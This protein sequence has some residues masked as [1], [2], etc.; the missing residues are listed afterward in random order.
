MSDDVRAASLRDL[1][2][3]AA[4]AAADATER[5]RRVFSVG[6]GVALLVALL[7]IGLV[8]RGAAGPGR[9]P[10][11]GQP[12]PD[13]ALT[14]FDGRLMRLSDLRGRPV[15]LNFWAS[16][17]PPCRAEAP[18]LSKVAAQ[19]GRV[20]FL[21]VDVRDRAGDAQ[22]FVNEFH[23]PYPN[24]RDA[25]GSLENHYGGFGIPFTVFISS[26]GTIERT[27]LG[28]LDERHLLAFIEE[29]T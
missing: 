29:L 20:A 26:A 28:P 15:V 22:D 27:W 17:C 25:D 5:G 7:V 12:A 4:E 24:V 21:G 11:A 3:D 19:A 2:A 6:L 1:A 16:W 8:Q 13:F 10:R 23:I 14:A 9:G 18:V